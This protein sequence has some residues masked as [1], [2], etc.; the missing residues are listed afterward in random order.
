MSKPK[1]KRP[2]P[3]PSA[4][5]FDLLD[6]GVRYAPKGVDFTPEPFYI[7][8]VADWQ[9]LVGFLHQKLTSEDYAKLP[10]LGIQ[11]QRYDFLPDEPEPE[12]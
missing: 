9:K 8:K 5:L 4:D 10:D 11:L 1:R 12:E 6:V 7:I 2:V 3:N